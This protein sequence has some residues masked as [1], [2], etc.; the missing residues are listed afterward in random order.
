MHAVS[1][2]QISN[3]R[4]CPRKIAWQFTSGIRPASGPGAELGDRVHKCLE[5]YLKYNQRDYTDIAQEILDPALPFFPKPGE[6]ETEEKFRFDWGG[7]L[8]TGR[9]DAR[10][11]L[12]VYDLKTT[13]DKKY[14]KTEEQ[15]K[16]DPQGIIYSKASGG[17]PGRWVYSLTTKRLAWAV[18][19]QPEGS[20]P[21]VDRILEDAETIGRIVGNK[22]AALDIPPN[23]AACG[24]YGGCP[25]KPYCT[26]ISPLKSIFKPMGI[27]LLS[28]LSSSGDRPAINPPE[29]AE[30]GP[31][32]VPEPETPKSKRPPKKREAA[33]SPPSAPTS[34]RTV[35]PETVES[36]VK[37]M[38]MVMTAPLTVAMLFIDSLPDGKMGADVIDVAVAIN[39]V[40]EG[41][42]K[43]NVENYRFLEYGQGAGIIAAKTIEWLANTEQSKKGELLLYIDSRLPESKLVLGTL[44][45]KASVTVRST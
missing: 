35:A 20:G 12:R 29:V 37:T 25:F 40:E 41:L 2:T 26:D 6:C 3:Y 11:H 39:A 8:F 15:L 19:F 42:K 5:K 14:A 1:P 30:S 38:A 44:R 43:D 27:D 23:T 32:P 7:L 13:K 17:L 18:D 31:P 9:T 10:T 22:V 45:A 34:S 28:R 36:E 24:D 21:E 16:K 33:P 4:A